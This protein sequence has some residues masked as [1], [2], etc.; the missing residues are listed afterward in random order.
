MSI[1][2]NSFVIVAFA[3]IDLVIL[4]T[5]CTFHIITHEIYSTKSQAQTS[6]SAYV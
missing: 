4:S 6:E 3:I 5:L 2:E 1:E